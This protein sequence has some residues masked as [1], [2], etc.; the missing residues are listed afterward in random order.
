MG[1]SFVQSNDAAFSAQLR[2][3]YNKLLIY[4]T[5]L[6]FTQAEVD[7]V[8]DD[9]ALWDYCLDADNKV[10]K[11]AQDYKKTKALLRKGGK[12]QVINAMPKAPDLQVAPAMVPVNIQLRFRQAAAKAKASPNYTKAIGSDLGIEAP[13]QT[14]DPTLGKPNLSIY[15][16]AGHPEIDYIKGKFS[17]LAIYKDTGEGYTLLGTAIKSSYTDNNPLPD[18]G[19]SQVWKYKAIYLWKNNEVGFWSDESKVVVSG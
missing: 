12:D 13:Q 7:S 18:A 6:G 16:N 10:E 17:G 9:S 5:L 1:K 4:F 2:N 15:L 14:F 11:Y 3:F 8:K 19:T